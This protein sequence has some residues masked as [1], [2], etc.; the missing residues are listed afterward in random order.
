MWIWWESIAMFNSRNCAEFNL[1][2]AVHLVTDHVK[3][4]GKNNGGNYFS[5][6]GVCITVVSITT[7][8]GSGGWG[9]EE[10]EEGRG[11]GGSGR[12]G[13][14]GTEGEEKERRGR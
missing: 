7:L 3:K 1:H 10:E 9:K 8:H 11:M 13:R 6:G 5:R 14:D 12:N 2:L 4:K